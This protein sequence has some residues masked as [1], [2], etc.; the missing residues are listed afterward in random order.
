MKE[1]LKNLC[2]YFLVVFNLVIGAIS[3]YSAV[4]SLTSNILLILAGI[5][6]ILG[7]CGSIA[8]IVEKA[9]KP[10]SDKMSEFSDGEVEISE[11]YKGESLRLKECFYDN[12]DKPDEFQKEI[13]VGCHYL[14]CQVKDV[15]T[16][17]LGKKVRVCI[18]MF[19]NDSNELIFTYCR[20]CFTIDKSI[21]KEHNQ[22]IDVTQ[23][24]DFYD[25]LNGNK[26]YFVGNDLRKEYE[27]H[28]YHNTNK[29]F[30]YNSTIVVP[31][32]ALVSEIVGNDERKYYD[33]IGFLCVDSKQK[34]LFENGQAQL[35]I[36]LMNAT[37]N[38]LYVFISQGNE[39]YDCIKENMEEVQLNGSSNS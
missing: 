17:A 16:A 39:Y 13:L 9:Y 11:I 31:I 21:K 38:Y 12:E 14:V 19:R 28:R 10:L 5:V 3:I 29:D 30:K 8:I 4:N 7:L 37:A 27:K 18:K 35:C 1:R 23:N 36:D 20:S 33:N 22:E 15:I 2:A 32:R 24:S 34:H 26:D 25:I 6:V